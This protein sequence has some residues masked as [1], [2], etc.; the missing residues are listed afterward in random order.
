MLGA[1]KTET[2]ATRSFCQKCGTTLFFESPRW[3]GEIHIV[4]S[5][6]EGAIDRE[7]D[8]HIYVDHKAPWFEIADGL[9]QRGG[10]SG[11]EP[12]D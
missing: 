6:I 10:E 8:F 2:G 3:K 9:P 5:N 1:Y 12:K 11:N 7:P 4:R